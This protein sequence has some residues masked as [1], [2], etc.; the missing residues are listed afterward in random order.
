M[1]SRRFWIRTTATTF[2]WRHSGG[3]SGHKLP[4]LFFSTAGGLYPEPP[5]VGFFPFS[6]LFSF[7]VVLSFSVLFYFL[8]LF[9]ILVPFFLT[10]SCVFFLFIVL[11]FSF[12]Y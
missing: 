7:P 6:G 9:F 1:L 8:F 12:F 10:F 11:F 4:P 5:A 2:H 3:G